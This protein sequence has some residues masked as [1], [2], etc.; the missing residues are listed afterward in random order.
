MVVRQNIFISPR[1]KQLKEKNCDGIV[2]FFIW[3]GNFYT[4]N[5]MY[6]LL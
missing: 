4:I 6:E 2:L 3:L 5:I 1:L